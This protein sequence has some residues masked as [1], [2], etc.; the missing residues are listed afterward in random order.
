MDFGADIAPAKRNVCLAGDNGGKA[1]LR[2]RA[3]GSVTGS[4]RRWWHGLAVHGIFWR[5]AIDWGVRVLPAFLHRPLIWIAAV[6]FFFAGTPA[7]T[8]LPRNLCVVRRGSWRVVNYF[9]VIRVFANFGWSLTDA[10]A[11]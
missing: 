6:L 2:G 10:A 5:R 11:Y 8:A 7:C 9:R 1:E 4:D 3:D